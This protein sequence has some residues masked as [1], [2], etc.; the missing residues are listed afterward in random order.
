MRWLPPIS[1]ESGGPRS[2]PRAAERGK[3]RGA[4]GSVAH[5]GTVPMAVAHN[6]RRDFLQPS[7]RAAGEYPMASFAVAREQVDGRIEKS[8]AGPWHLALPQSHLDRGM[9]V[10]SRVW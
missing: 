2:P 4:V 7:E 6:L 8:A 1:G 9:D 3:R 5:D 10:T